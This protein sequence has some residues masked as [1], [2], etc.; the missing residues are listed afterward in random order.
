MFKSSKH[1]M[2]L[3][4]SKIFISSNLANVNST[5]DSVFVRQAQQENCVIPYQEPSFEEQNSAQKQYYE[6]KS[7]KLQPGTYVYLDFKQGAFDKSFD[8]QVKHN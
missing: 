8:T 2:G 4:S 5:E 6:N 1:A 3:Q 7:N